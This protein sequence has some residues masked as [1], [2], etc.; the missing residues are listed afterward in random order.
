MTKTISNYP[1]K[2]CLRIGF[3]LPVHLYRLGLGWL[4][5][6]RFV[7]IHHLGRITGKPRQAVVEIVERDKETGS[8]TVVAGYGPRTQ[9]YQNLKA[10]PDTSIQVGS[11]KYEVTAE[12]ISAGEGEEIILRYRDH[13]GN[14]V[15]A[16]FSILGYDWDGT[17][18]GLR[19]IARGSLR[20]VRFI[21]QHGQDGLA[22]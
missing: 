20:F 12:F 16:F 17:E 4:L 5:G 14:I 7:L 11:R 19:Q 22:G 10:H 15:G 6:G 2:G 1:P 9:W 13:Y 21:P 3:R 8:I 18:G